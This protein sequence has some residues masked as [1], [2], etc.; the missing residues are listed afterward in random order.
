MGFR[1]LLCR[2]AL[3]HAHGISTR[4]RDAVCEQ[5]L[6]LTVRIRDFNRRLGSCGYM[7]H[8]STAGDRNL[9]ESLREPPRSDCLGPSGNVSPLG[10]ALCRAVATHCYACRPCTNALKKIGYV[11]KDN[12]KVKSPSSEFGTDSKTV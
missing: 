10:G 11:L 12:S 5:D 9:N 3:A 2:A 8:F 7:V 6:A 4:S 1:R